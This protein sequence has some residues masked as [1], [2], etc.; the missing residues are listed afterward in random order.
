MTL[1]CLFPSLVSAGPQKQKG[2]NPTRKS[3]SVIFSWQLR[4]SLLAGFLVICPSLGPLFPGVSITLF[5]AEEV[6]SI[7][8]QCLKGSA[9]FSFSPF[10][11]PPTHRRTQ[12]NSNY[13]EIIVRTTIF[14]CLLLLRYE[15]KHFI[16]MYY[17]NN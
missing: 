17:P 16:Y 11:V 10:F 13:N 7:T 6:L 14:D 8:I 1:F 2:Q 12:N 5:R 15:T 9:L 4:R 3:V